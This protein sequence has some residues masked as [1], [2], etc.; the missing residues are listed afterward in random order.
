MIENRLT[1]LNAATFTPMQSDG[2][3][4]LSVVEPM[5]EHLLGKGISG[6]Y[7]LG[8][9]GEGAS[10][11]GHERRAVA[12]A[13][14]KAADGRLPVIVQVGHKSPTEARQLA[15][16]A[17][18][19][20]VTAISAVP[21]SYFKIDSAETL[22]SCMAE[23]ACGAPATPFYY[24]HVPALTG[25]GIS[26]LEF[27]RLASDR[28]PTLAGIKYTAPTVYE[29][30]ACLE[31]ADRRYDILHG[32]DEML[33]AGLA[34]GVSGAISS[35][36][37]FAAPMYRH[38][39]QAFSRGDMEGARFWQARAYNMI[40]VVLRH[41]G[42]AGQK[43]M[44]KL[45]GLD[46]GPTRLPVPYLP[47]AE[48]PE[49]LEELKTLGFFEWIDPTT[50]PDENEHPHAMQWLPHRRDNAHDGKVAP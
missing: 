29:L 26:M 13:F 7:V 46:C 49:L 18:Q 3:L 17:Q 35:T 24:Y 45:I 2:S 39:T 20:G 38:L 14:V 23:V 40:R 19:I 44:M 33:L 16:H 4:N 50:L 42:L 34:F 15:A 36:C 1:G 27:L 30:Q 41:R 25:C 10:L 11:S 37:N 31:F 8:S 32:T 28:I 47:D 21:P 6:L 9:T 5:V 43:A 48:H 12:A 22:V